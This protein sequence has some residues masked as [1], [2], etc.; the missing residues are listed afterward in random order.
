[1]SQSMTD[2]Y[3]LVRRSIESIW[4]TMH[5]TSQIERPKKFYDSFGT[6]VPRTASRQEMTGDDGRET[7]DKSSSYKT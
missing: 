4:N 2:N 7:Q 6:L 5:H 3:A 1:M